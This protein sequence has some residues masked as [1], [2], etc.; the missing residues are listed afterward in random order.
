MGL[1]LI[2]EPKRILI[3]RKSVPENCEGHVILHLNDGVQAKLTF[4][5]A[6]SPAPTV[7]K[8]VRNDITILDFC[9]AKVIIKQTKGSEEADIS[10]EYMVQNCN[11]SF[12][13]EPISEAR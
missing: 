11:F 13:Y 10:V 8:D 9:N 7:L 5:K 4:Q 1:S 6:A 2:E 12:C 3:E